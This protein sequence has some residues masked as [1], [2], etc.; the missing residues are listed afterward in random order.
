MV[1]SQW[2]YLTDHFES[3]LKVIVRHILGA[4]LWFICGCY[5]EFSDLCF[6]F[7]T[8]LQDKS[9]LASAITDPAD[10]GLSCMQE[11]EW[12]E[13]TSID[14]EQTLVTLNERRKAS[15]TLNTTSTVHVTSGS[16]ISQV[17]SSGFKPGYWFRINS[18]MPAYSHDCFVSSPACL[19]ET[20][21][22][23]AQMKHHACRAPALIVL[24]TKATR[25]SD[26][27]SR[28]L[29]ITL[30]LSPFYK[31]LWPVEDDSSNIRATVAVTSRSSRTSCLSP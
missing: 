15:D 30:P 27:T 7:S 5:V 21:S 4:K 18:L 9:W 25:H 23:F 20:E 13:L 10:R 28:H 14:Y 16:P 6:D 17:W 2:N 31:Y 11:D 12:G 19:R 29:L 26:I 8:N 1:I 22:Q 24:L 3:D